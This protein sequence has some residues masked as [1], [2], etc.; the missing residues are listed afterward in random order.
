MFQLEPVYACQSGATMTI[1]YYRWTVE[2]S[3]LLCY[4]LSSGTL[5]W[6]DGACEY[7]YNVLQS[8]NWLDDTHPGY[9][10]KKGFQNLY[11]WIH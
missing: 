7:S 9:S 5:Y 8:I 1:F 4:M 2:D 3:K 11:N 6:H 10:S